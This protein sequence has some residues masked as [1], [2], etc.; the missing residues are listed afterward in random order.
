MALSDPVAATY[1]GVAKSLP[2]SGRNET[3]STYR[4]VDAGNVNFTLSIEHQLPTK[5]GRN[6][7]TV[8]LTRE[9][10]VNDPLATGQ[11]KK[12]QCT[13]STTVDYDAALLGPADA[14]SLYSMMLTFLTSAILLRVA[15]GET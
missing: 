3:S 1:A 14:Q 9:G 7:A 12:A 15:G 10:L 4:L 6:R 13:V 2:L 11:Q 5:A 8:R